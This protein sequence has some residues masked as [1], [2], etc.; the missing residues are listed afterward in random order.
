MF[1]TTDEMEHR[2]VLFFRCFLSSKC[3]NEEKDSSRTHQE[4]ARAPNIVVRESRCCVAQS[5]IQHHFE[6]SKSAMGADVAHG[7]VLSRKVSESTPATL[8]ARKSDAL[9]TLCPLICS[10]NRTLRSARVSPHPKR[11]TEMVTG[12]QG[13]PIEVVWGVFKRRCIWQCRRKLGN[14][15]ENQQTHFKTHQQTNKNIQTTQ[16]HD[17]F[18]S[19]VIGRGGAFIMLCHVCCHPS[20]PTRVPAWHYG[21]SKLALGHKHFVP[22][23]PSPAPPTID[24]MSKLVRLLASATQQRRQ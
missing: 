1:I 3:S 19:C 8:M 22:A 20:K 21:G 14:R 9:P 7:G 13:R 10:P 11:R 24:I 5:V 17:G 4:V 12:T 23:R 6:K 15:A 16:T 18:R 2:C